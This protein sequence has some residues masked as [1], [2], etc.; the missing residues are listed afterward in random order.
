MQVPGARLHAVDGMIRRPF[1][2]RNL[3]LHQCATCRSIICAPANSEA[4]R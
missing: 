2:L 3:P 4:A 1:A